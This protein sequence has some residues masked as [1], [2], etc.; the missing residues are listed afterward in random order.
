MS[1]GIGLGLLL[2]VLIWTVAVLAAVG[3]A[4]LAVIEYFPGGSGSP[5]RESTGAAAGRRTPKAASRS[6]DRRKVSEA[7]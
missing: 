3:L 5:A 6:M 1:V 7:S 2:N 4:A